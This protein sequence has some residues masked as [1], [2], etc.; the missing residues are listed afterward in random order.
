MTFDVILIFR[1]TQFRVF[2]LSFAYND[3]WFM[4]LLEKHHEE[5][6]E[7]GINNQ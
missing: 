6:L 7:I 3:I 1:K 4:K 2:S 5:W